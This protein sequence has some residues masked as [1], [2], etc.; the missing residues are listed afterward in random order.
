[1]GA[2]A[3]SYDRSFAGH[4]VPLNNSLFDELEPYRSLNASRLKVVGQGSFDATPYLSPELCMAYRFP[5]AL[6]IDRVPKAFE[7]SQKLDSLG[8]VVALARLWDARGLLHIH[9][10]DI[11]KGARHELVRVFNC[12]KNAQC[13]RQIGDRRGRNAVEMRV[14]GPSASLPTGADLRILPLMSE[15]K[16]CQSSA[17]TGKISIISSQPLGIGQDQ[18]LK[19]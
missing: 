5:D 2:G 17:L 6:L 10:V 1:M 7:Y 13:D 19:P 11:Q 9:D 12:L 15:V 3:S 16:R 14:L 4:D 8:E 18:T